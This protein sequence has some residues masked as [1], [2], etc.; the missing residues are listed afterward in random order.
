GGQQPVGAEWKRRNGPSGG[1]GGDCV[2]PVSP[3]LFGNGSHA[4]KRPAI[5]V[6]AKCRIAYDE[7]VR[8]PRQGK[9][10]LDFDAARPVGLRAE[11][12]TRRRRFDTRG[13]H[14]G[15]ALDPLSSQGDSRLVAHGHRGSDAD[16]DTQLLKRSP[17]VA[18]ERWVKLT[19]N[20]WSGLD[21]HNL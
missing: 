2:R 8:Q 13:P 6:E 5:T 19:Q 9:I 18:R 17:S 16:L 11:P 21:Q 14:D 3:L 7:N 4:R 12:L 20:A 10:R 1:A 15:P